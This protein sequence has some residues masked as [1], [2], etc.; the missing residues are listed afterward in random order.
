MTSRIDTRAA[1]RWFL[2]RGLP[3]VLTPRGRFTAV[4]P[5][6]AP[7][8]A[9]VAVLAVSRLVVYWLTGDRYVSIDSIDV[10]TV[11]RVVLVVLA[12]AVPVAAIAGWRTAR[13]N[14]DR[15]QSIVSAVASVVAI[16]CDVLQRDVLSL[17]STGGII[18]AI[19]ALTVTGVGSVLGWATR[20]T[21]AQLRAVGALMIG[22]LPVVLLIV[23]VFFNTYVWIM[24]ATITPKRLWLLVAILVTIAVTFV[25][26]RTIERARPTLE[27]ASASARHLER[28]AG[29]PFEQ[30][31][32]PPRA[33]PLTR[34]ERWNEVFILAASQIA[35]ILTV[36]LVSS[37]VFF[38]IGLVVLSP[39]L[40]ERWAHGGRPDAEIFG[41]LV[42]VPQALLNMT[43]FLAALTFMYISARVVSDSEY[44][45]TFLE[46]LIDDLKLT[47]VA[48][49]RYRYNCPASVSHE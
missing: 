33:D 8:L 23:L 42:P 21:W 41:M 40:L 47:M 44:R 12:L 39:E 22:V 4:W 45:G 5:R 48:R 24:S 18:V 11:E 37:G 9:A 16:V 31:A 14:A 28:L 34:G 27:S 15:S 19:L 29:T 49:S 3:S 13:L 46:P 20:L 17:V 43:V 25:V 30:M 2:D 35:Q 6:S 26:S 32:D 10:T 36:L 7:A 1:D 38:V